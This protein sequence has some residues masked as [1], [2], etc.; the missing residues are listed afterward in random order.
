MDSSAQNVTGRCLC[1]GVTF[2]V[3]AGRRE[4]DACHCN[5]CRRWSAGPYIGFP[6]DGELI[7][8][9]G[10]NVSLYKSSEWAERAFCKRCGSSL[11]YHLLGTDH[12]SFSAGL[13]D[14][15]DG[16]S[17]TQEIFIDEKPGYYDLANSTPKLT[18]AEVFAAFEA[19]SDD[20]E[21]RDG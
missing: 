18:G 19:K 8:Q 12:Y 16:L 15:Q 14:D 20:T 4:V 9:G 7:L 11:Y 3:A 21:A 10:D 17:L 13:L 5:M 1:G 2:S 6:H